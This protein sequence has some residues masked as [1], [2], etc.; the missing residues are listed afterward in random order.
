MKMKEYVGQLM[1]LLL[2]YAFFAFPDQM[3]ASSITPLGR[4]IS[5]VIIT[6]Y[7]CIHPLYGLAMCA[8]IILYYQMDCVEGFAANTEYY[9]ELLTA[10]PV[11]HIWNSK[12]D[13]YSEYFT[14]KEDE[15]R[16]DH[17]EKDTLM[18]KSQTVKPE[19]ASHIFPELSFTNDT[20]NPCDKNCGISISKRLDV[21]EELIYPKVNTDW[22]S[23]IWDTWFSEDKTVPYAYTK[24]NSHYN[25]F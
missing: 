11:L 16:Q 12:Y 4:F 23:Q 18:H 24:T 7:T 2:F 9:T 14:T 19:N 3:L 1:P 8:F 21:Q 22:V 10:E 20:C 13:R 5:I 17:C 25:T 6:F 15:F